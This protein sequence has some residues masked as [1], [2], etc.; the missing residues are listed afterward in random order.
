MVRANVETYMGRMQ[1]VISHVK[2][3]D[4]EEVSLADFLP[5]SEHDPKEM[6]KELG[7]I[8]AT[9][10]TPHLK[11]L[12]DAFFSDEKFAASFAKCPAAVSL[13]HAFLGGLLEHTLC[14][15]RMA[16]EVAGH[17]EH[18]D[19]DMLI[20]GAILHDLGKVEEI[21]H[22]R[23]FKYSDRGG[24]I[25]H[26]VIGAYEIEKRAAKIKGFPPEKL[27]ELQH[28][29]LSHHGEYIY[30]SPKLP[31]TAEAMALHYLDNLDAKMQ[32]FREA[33][34]AEG[35]WTEWLRMFERRLYIP[36]DQGGTS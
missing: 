31:M 2:R 32:A 30:G 35:N 15:T 28:L 10:E 11:E 14:V 18:L 29:I 22:A 7:E 6:M 27:T 19:R 26:L 8:I 9:V 36:Q 21:E 25:G 4:D 20:A 1:L 34:P 16:V 24:L 13:H 33:E 17:Y 3:L 12:L 5:A 23:V